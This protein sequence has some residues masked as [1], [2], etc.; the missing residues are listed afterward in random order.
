MEAMIDAAVHVGF[1]RETAKKIV[2]ATIRGSATYAQHSNE[3]ITTLK[4]N[5][6]S[7]L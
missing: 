1:P 2:I 7:S 4:N 6:S 3:S 5:V